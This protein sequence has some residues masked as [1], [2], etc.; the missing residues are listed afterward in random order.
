MRVLH[1]VRIQMALLRRA[2][3]ALKI[4]E[5]L[6]AGPHANYAPPNRRADPMSTGLKKQEGGA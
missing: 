5:N 6:L 1:L 3:R 4:I 2:Q